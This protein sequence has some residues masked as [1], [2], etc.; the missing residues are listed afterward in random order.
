MIVKLRNSSCRFALANLAFDHRRQDFFGEALADRALQVAELDQLHLGAARAEHEPLL[1]DAGQLGFDLG[2]SF[3][4]ARIAAAAAALA[5][6][7]QDGDR[8]D[9]EEADR[10]GQLDHALAPL[11]RSGL[12]VFPQALFAAYLAITATAHGSLPT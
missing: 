3:D 8:H 2:G 10:A 5:D 1:R 7:D 6:H 12:F 9:G 4:V 11:G